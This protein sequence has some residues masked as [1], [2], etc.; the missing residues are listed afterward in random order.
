MSKTALFHIISLS[1]QIGKRIFKATFKVLRQSDKD[2]QGLQCNC[3]IVWFSTLCTLAYQ[4]TFERSI[5]FENVIFW[6]DR[7]CRRIQLFYYISF[8][9]RCACLIG[10]QE[11]LGKMKI[12]IFALLLPGYLALAIDKDVL[13]EVNLPS[14]KELTSNKNC[15]TIPFKM[16]LEKPGCKNITI[17]NNYCTGYCRS[18]F[19]GPVYGKRPLINVCLTCKPDKKHSHKKSILLECAEN[20]NGIKFKKMSSVSVTIVEKCTCSFSSC[21]PKE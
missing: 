1:Q 8:F 21:K 19:V 15:L 20:R 7:S 17:D 13:K 9:F 6:Y 12:L 18:L 3:M 11:L 16:P 5:F 4:H 14:I 10:Y 2:D